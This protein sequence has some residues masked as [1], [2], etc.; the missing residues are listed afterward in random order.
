MIEITKFDLHFASFN[1]KKIKISVSFQFTVLK[2]KNKL[3]I[4]NQKLSCIY[5]YKQKSY[6]SRF[7]N[8]MD[9]TDLEH[10]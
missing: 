6:F 9:F 2:I 3:I 1:P 5:L 10:F 8:N 4:S 7:Q